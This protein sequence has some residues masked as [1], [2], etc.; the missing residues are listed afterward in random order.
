MVS[1]IDMWTCDIVCDLSELEMV[2][3]AWMG[4]GVIGDGGGMGDGSGAEVSVP[5]ESLGEE[6]E[7]FPTPLEMR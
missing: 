2:A 3:C 1:S 7:L 6:K 5:G 4:N